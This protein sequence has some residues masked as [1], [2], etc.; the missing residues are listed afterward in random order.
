MTV[1]QSGIDGTAQPAGLRRRARYSFF[2]AQLNLWLGRRASAQRL[3]RRA[4]S[5]CDYT[6][7]YRMLSQLEL[8]GEHYFRVLARVHRHVQPATYLEV[9]VSRGESLA[10]AC[11]QTLAL[12]IDPEPHLQ[13]ELA[14]NQKVFAQTSDDFFARADVP[15]LLGNRPLEMAF[16]DGMHHFEYALRDF[17]NIEPLCRPG[18]LVFI[19]DCFPI[20]ARSAD[21]EQSTGFWSGDIWRLIVLLKKYRPDLAIHTLGTPPTGL[22]LITHLDPR[23][24]VLRGRL[25]ELIAE[26]MALTFASI[27]DRRAQALNLM[28]CEWPRVRQLLDARQDIRY[29]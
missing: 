17:I 1:N 21:R 6:K 18:S 23:S 25:P 28:P 7:A 16:I 15:A 24:S 3:C 5:F 10:L 19:H 4:L 2:G 27:A 22:G 12:G 20:D 14:P 13:F 29:R 8:P 26:G 11:P 9:G